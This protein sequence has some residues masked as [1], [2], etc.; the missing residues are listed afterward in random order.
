MHKFKDAQDSQEEMIL[1]LGERVGCAVVKTQ[2]SFSWNKK[3]RDSTEELNRRGNSLGAD[4]NRIESL[5]CLGIIHDIVLYGC[6]S[7]EHGEHVSSYGKTRE[8]AEPE[9]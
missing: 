2:S 8:S 3:Q 7:E 9:F 6:G 1:P 5:R 4:S